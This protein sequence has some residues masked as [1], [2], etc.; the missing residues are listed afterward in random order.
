MNTRIAQCNILYDS[1]QMQ[2]CGD[3]ISVGQVVNLSCIKGE[4]HTCACGINVDF[5]EDHHAGGSNCIIR[6]KVTRI[7]SVF[8]DHF[9]NIKDG[10]HYIDDPENT[11]SIIEVNAIDGWEEPLCYEHRKGG[12]VCYYIITLENA[13]ECVLE[14]HEHYPLYQ[15]LYI[16]L[17]PYED[18]FDVFW[19][20]GGSKMGTVNELTIY[21]G[22]KS[23]TIDL[24]AFWWHKDLLSWHKFFQDNIRDGYDRINN[25]E[26]LKWWS[27][28]WELAKE[29][30]KLLPADIE[31]NYG[32]LSQ[33]VQVLEGAD[34]NTASTRI[35]FPKHMQNKIA[36]GLFIPYAYID[37]EKDDDKNNNYLF[38]INC[39]HD[40]HP[41]DRVM[42]GVYGRPQYQ[43]GTVLQCTSAG[44]L[45]H[46]DWS[47]DISEAYS[48]ELIV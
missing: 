2:C 29:I 13:V 37:W 26:W 48:I 10:T 31:L 9:A 12:D 30:R 24:T 28:G 3:P 40:L 33:A 35:S 41:D 16:N 6:G 23:Q 8:V 20:E 38:S 22:K 36:E 7:R 39:E 21:K 34:L 32:H 42:L 47:L 1:W 43:T 14:G 27:K 19:D 25:L 15:G 17:E 4:P 44:L 46:T 45:I 18:S 5:D 11:F